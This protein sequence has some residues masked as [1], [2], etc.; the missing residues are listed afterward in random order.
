MDEKKRTV[1]RQKSISLRNVSRKSKLDDSQ[2]KSARIFLIYFS[3]L[4]YILI[5]TASITDA[6][7]I[8]NDPVK[9]PLI[10]TEVS[11]TTFFVISPIIL[12]LLFTFFNVHLLHLRRAK[13][14]IDNYLLWPVF[15]FGKFDSSDKKN[16]ILNR[17]QI[18]ISNIIMWGLLPL[19]LLVIWFRYSN[20]HDIPLMLWQLI[21]AGIGSIVA[22]YFWNKNNDSYRV[23][24][25]LIFTFIFALVTYMAYLIFLK[26]FFKENIFTHTNKDLILIIIVVVIALLISTLASKIIDRISWRQVFIDIWILLLISPLL[27]VHYML[28]ISDGEGRNVNLSYQIISQNPNAP[29]QSVYSVNLRSK[30]LEGANLV[31]S[32]LANADL[33]DAHLQYSS[34]YRAKLNGADLSDVD[35]RF[36]DLRKSDF[37]NTI[38]RNADFLGAQLDDMRLDSADLR[39]AKG[40]HIDSLCEVHSLYGA[41]L[42]TNLLAQVIE[43][44]PE[45]IGSTSQ[46]K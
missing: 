4:I 37:S 34:L 41:K 20:T 17:L 42:D 5:T 1:I 43:K 21:W 33:R 26:F 27:N 30:H 38:L 13:T 40:L 23:I 19:T 46:K 3:T 6:Q 7:L 8:L 16:N 12:I 24:R 44:R 25:S 11:T 28:H 35:L 18:L 36:T 14:A 39:G 15:E 9:L 32:V 45:L 22:G 10:N 29:Y 31:A 2:K